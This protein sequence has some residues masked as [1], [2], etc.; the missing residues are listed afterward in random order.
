M[1]QQGCIVRPT[2]GREQDRYFVVLNR[3]GQTAIISDG[4]KRKLQNPKRKNVRHLQDTG[5]QMD[6]ADMATNKQLRKALR[7]KGFFKVQSL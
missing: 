1:I 2:A 5:V 3:E 7:N 6:S 4:R